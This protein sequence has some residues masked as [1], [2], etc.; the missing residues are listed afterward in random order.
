[1]PQISVS[2]V[3]VLLFGAWLVENGCCAHPRIPPAQA[4]MVVLQ[5]GDHALTVHIINSG[6]YLFVLPLRRSL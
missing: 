2:L 4:G 3:S 6:L 5:D 1:M